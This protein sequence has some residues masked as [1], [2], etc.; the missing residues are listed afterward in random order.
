MLYGMP[1]HIEKFLIKS[2][3]KLVMAKTI[4]RVGKP[5]NRHLKNMTATFSDVSFLLCFN[6]L[7]YSHTK[8][9]TPLFS[10]QTGPT[11]GAR[12]TRW[13]KRVKLPDWSAW[14]TPS[15][16]RPRSRGPTQLERKS[17]LPCLGGSPR[18]SVQYCHC[19]NSQT[20]TFFQTM[21]HMSSTYPKPSLNLPKTHPKHT[22]N[23]TK[24][25]PKPILVQS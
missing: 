8:L 24:T 15:L 2:D 20:S 23:L 21:L 5:K 1:I 22:P 4:C 12:R 9:T 11:F 14:P 19:A 16:N 6:H 25:Y 17:T 10:P 7:I 3:R 13:P 18:R